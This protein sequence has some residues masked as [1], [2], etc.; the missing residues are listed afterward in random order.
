VEIPSAVFLAIVDRIETGVYA[1]DRNRKVVYWNHGAEQITGYLRQEVLGREYRSDLVVENE[2]HCPLVCVHQC[3]LASPAGAG[4]PQR[5]MT[6]LR[7]RAGHVVPVLLWTLTL[8]N[9]A[10]QIV[11]SVKVFSEQLT[12]LEP[13]HASSSANS[14]ENQDADT[15][16][17]DRVTVEAFLRAQCEVAN[18]TRVSCGVIAIQVDFED[19]SHAHGK[20]AASALMRE[21]GYTLEEMVR[22]T[23]LVG[24][25]GQNCFVAV[26]PDCGA[27]VLE[28]VAGRMR[29][30][31]GRVAI[32]WTGDRLSTAVEVRTGLIAPGEGVDGVLASLF[33]TPT[34]DSAK[35]NSSPSAGA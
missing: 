33:A 34:T 21:V 13:R 27:V 5:I 10:G 23:D 25:W 2:D 22:G 19:F 20:A 1:V 18:L 35:A 24:R 16:L 29:R 8:K 14:T 4:W 17:P 32:P 7:H 6:Y 26:L 28:R 15:G 30:V 12:A 9:G 31:S 11:G 3:P